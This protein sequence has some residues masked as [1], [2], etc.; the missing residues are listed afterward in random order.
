MKGKYKSFS[1]GKLGF[2]VSTLPE[3]VDESFVIGTT[4]GDFFGIPPGCKVYAPLGDT[5]CAFYSVIKLQPQSYSKLD[6]SLHQFEDY[7]NMYFPDWTV[8]E[9]LPPELICISFSVLNLGTSCQLG[10]IHDHSCG[11]LLTEQSAGQVFPYF[12]DK[13]L[14]L[15]ASMNGGNVLQVSSAFIMSALSM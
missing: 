5:Q 8:L 13:M 15:V 2:D 9:F 1:L 10:K 6:T 14:A 4:T 7:L 3:V 12:E 11:P